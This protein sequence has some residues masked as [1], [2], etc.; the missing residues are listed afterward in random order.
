[1]ITTCMAA[2]MTVSGLL[3]AAAQ[4]LWV[5]DYGIYGAPDNPTVADNIKI[6]SNTG[7]LLKTLKGGMV[8][9]SSIVFDASGNALVINQ[10]VDAIS[11]Y[12]AKGEYMGVFATTG[13]YSAQGLAIDKA[14]NVYVGNT[15]SITKYASN[16]AYLGVFA[17]A[18]VGS[19]V[20]ELAIA[21]DGTL[22]SSN[23]NLNTVSAYAP[24]GTYLRSM[25][26]GVDP[27]GLLVDSSGNL[28]VSSY[29]S[30]TITEFNSSGSQINSFYLGS[31]INPGGMVFDAAGNLLV[32]NASHGEIDEY[33]V[34]GSYLGVFA[35]GG[36]D[37]NYHM[38]WAPVSTPEPS[39]FAL[40]AVGGLVLARGCR[41]RKH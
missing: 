11:E 18:G 41:R 13:I 17:T 32:A 36:L 25:P 7:T 12:N 2:A 28:F 26:T 27:F 38:A 33:S 9:P 29:V 19:G 35:T 15:G 24:D 21:P 31:N 3:S 6:F 30:K 23:Q 34:S 16:G 8:N 10:G 22:Y 4:N 39:A 14:G 1:M 20:A 5:T 40:F 37:Y